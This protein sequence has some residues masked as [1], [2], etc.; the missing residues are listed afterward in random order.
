VWNRHFCRTKKDL[1]T[2][3]VFLFFFFF[4]FLRERRDEFFF[5]GVKKPRNLIPH[6][7]TEAD[8]VG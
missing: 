1:D 4:F 2:D 6:P 7:G 5:G 3:C 8:R